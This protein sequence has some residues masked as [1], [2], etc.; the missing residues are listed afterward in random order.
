MAE[1]EYNIDS[2][3]FNSAAQRREGKEGRIKVR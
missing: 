1:V 3:T 2:L